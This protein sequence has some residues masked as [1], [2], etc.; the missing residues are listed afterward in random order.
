MLILLNEPDAFVHYPE[1]PNGSAWCRVKAVISALDGVLAAERE[2]GVDAGRVRLSVTWSFAM[3]DSIDGK[4]DGPGIFGFEDT[5][6]AIADPSIAK[7]TPRSSK[8]ELEHAFQT[9]WA[10]GL[11]TQSPWLF[12]KEKIAKN[13]ARFS[14]VP[15]FIGEYGA[16]NQFKAT[17]QG[18]LEDMTNWAEENSDF[19]GT[20]FFQFQTAYWRGG[21]K[22]NFGHYGLFSMGVDEKSLGDVTPPCPFVTCRSWPIHCLSTNLS[23]LTGTKAER[24]AAV[25]AAWGG[26]LQKVVGSSPGFCKE[27]ARRLSSVSEDGTRIACK[28]RAA[29]GLDAKDVSR[30]LQTDTF[31]K[32]VEASTRKVLSSNSDAI[33]GELLLDNAVVTPEEESEDAPAETQDSSLKRWLPQIIAVALLVV[34]V[35]LALWGFLAH[36]KRKARR[37]APNAGSERV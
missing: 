33:V 28:I 22:M 8:E 2:A 23:W 5:V 13:Y 31:S 19:L 35:G 36:R 11:N 12:I 1:C 37:A 18:D 4:E 3:M 14:P 16:N 9:R 21:G 6:A 26:S 27:A 15:W 24:A 29:A 20:T 32:S 25:A 17:I 34:A 10:H 30:R 7:Y